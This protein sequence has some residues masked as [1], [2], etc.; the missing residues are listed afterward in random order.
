MSA[1]STQPWERKLAD[2]ELRQLSGRET[3]SVIV[4]LELPRPR[5]EME[6]SERGG[7]GAFRPRRVELEAEDEQ[8]RLEQ[9]IAPAGAFLEQLVGSTPVWLAAARAFGIEASG[10]QLRTIARSPLVRTIYLSRA[11]R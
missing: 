5:V 8:R 3:A 6:R 11:R 1:D 2:A 10:D 9:L 7:I 4:Q